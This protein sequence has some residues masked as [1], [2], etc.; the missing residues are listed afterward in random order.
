[1]VALGTVMPVPADAGLNSD[2]VKYKLYNWQ[3]KE[4]EN[5]FSSVMVY[6]KNTGLF[7]V[8]NLYVD[9]KIQREVTGNNLLDK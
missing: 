6:V 8:R 7:R 5:V 9:V 1:M 2:D 3:K 4:N